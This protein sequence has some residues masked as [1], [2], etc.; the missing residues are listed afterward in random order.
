MTNNFYQIKWQKV[1]NVMKNSNLKISRIAQ[2]GS[3]AKK[4]ES[5]YSDMDVI[6]SVAGNPSREGFYPNLIKVLKA[7]FSEEYIYPG[8][9]YN[10]VHLNFKTGGKFDLVLLKENKFDQEHK[11]ILEFKRKN[12]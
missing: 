6:F 5:P 4:Q 1:V 10:V 7:N 11:S 12:L 9:N 3:R 8:S 2:A